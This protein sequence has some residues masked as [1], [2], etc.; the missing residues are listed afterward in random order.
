MPIAQ[1]FT[2]KKDF[3]CNEWR[4]KNRAKVFCSRPC[5]EKEW[6]GRMADSNKGRPSH[7]RGQWFESVCPVCKKAFMN[8]KGGAVKTFC[9]NSCSTKHTSAKRN[10]LGANNPSWKGG[11]SIKLGYVFLRI[12]NHP[13]ANKTGYIQEHIYI[14][15]KALGKALPPGVLVHHVN[16]DRSDNRP[17]NLVICPNQEYHKLLHKRTK[18]HNGRGQQTYQYLNTK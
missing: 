13:R 6:A 16:G 4:L 11:R 15:E 3:D 12:P 8:G 5:Y 17:Q 1:C 18:G 9:S 2:C 7:N 14:A 10:L